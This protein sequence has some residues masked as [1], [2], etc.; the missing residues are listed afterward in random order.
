MALNTSAIYLGQAL[1]ASGGGWLIAHGGGYA[2]L[3]FAGLG[4]MAAALALS[5]WAARRTARAA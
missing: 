5:A 1:G 3:P 2:P 4:W